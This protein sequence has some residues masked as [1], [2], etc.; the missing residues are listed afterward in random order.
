MSI[1]NPWT[2]AEIA[3]LRHLRDIDHMAFQDIARELVR[4]EKSCHAKYWAMRESILLTRQPE[5]GMRINVT[6]EAIAD[7]DARY[8]LRMQQSPVAALLGDPLPGRSALDLRERGEH[9]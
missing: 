2:A 7:R 5:A 3:R 8:Q 9:A 4:T 1:K 6:P